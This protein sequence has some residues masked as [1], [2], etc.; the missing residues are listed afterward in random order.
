MKTNQKLN[1]EFI[2]MICLMFILNLVDI[3]STYYFTPDLKYESNRVVQYLG[4]TWKNLVIVLFTSLVINSIFVFY[5]MQLFSYPYNR[6]FFFRNNISGV[7]FFFTGG[8]DLK[9]EIFRQCTKSILFLLGHFI[10]CKY[11]I[12][13]LLAIFY[14]YIVG[15]FIIFSDVKG[16]SSEGL[17]GCRGRRNI[18][19][20]E[21][22]LWEICF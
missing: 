9:S 10:F 21:Y 14:N 5:S 4:L 11:I 7:I 17:F 12:D 6:N 20:L 3:H 13:K 1:K 2:I 15:Y 8:S 19:N 22:I 16:L 18:T